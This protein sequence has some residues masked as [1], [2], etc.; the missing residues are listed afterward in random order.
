MSDSK[1]NT[2]EVEIMKQGV[3]INA[4]IPVDY[5]YRINQFLFEFF[6]VRD[7]DHL[8]EILDNIQKGNDDKDV[9]TYHFRTFLSLMLLLEEAAK[10]QGHVE[11][12][13]ITLNDTDD[14]EGDPQ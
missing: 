2:R 12:K 4:N 7:K 9:H 11:K 5:Y 13:V 8:K 3:V 1:P 14:K 10:E 6:P